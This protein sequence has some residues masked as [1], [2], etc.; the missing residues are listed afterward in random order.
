[1]L[2]LAVD[3]TTPAGSV[4]LLDD[5]RLIAEFGQ[6]SPGTH[7]ARLMKSIDFILEAAGLNIR[8]V[9]IYAVAAGPGSFTGIRIGIGSVKAL[10]FASGRPAVGVSTLEALAAKAPV[11][12]G[13]LV[14]ALIDAKRDEM[15]A[16]LYRKTAADLIEIIPAGAYVPDAFLARLPARRVIDFVGNGAEVF[17]KKIF[18][19][20]RDKA[21][22]PV[23]SFFIAPEVGRLAYR[24]IL[25]GRADASAGLEPIYLRKSQAEEK[26][27][28]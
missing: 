1:M 15:Y 20:V 21:R 27:R 6:E 19:Y 17:R 18:A 10:A 24:K 14:C 28:P 25:A 3:S 4:A 2:I 26:C 12:A 8:D 7:S 22:F 9:E 5:G 13:R 23:R 11:E 16:A